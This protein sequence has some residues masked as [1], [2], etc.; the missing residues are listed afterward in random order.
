ML[1][2]LQHVRRSHVE[3]DKDSSDAF[4]EE[5]KAGVKESK[6]QSDIRTFGLPS[7]G[8]SRDRLRRGD[9]VTCSAPGVIAERGSREHAN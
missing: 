2:A 9:G 6:G 5:R 4:M 1:T 8:C 7:P 3:M